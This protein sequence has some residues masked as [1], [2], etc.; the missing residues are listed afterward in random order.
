M[1]FGSCQTF[2]AV[3]VFNSV[4]PKWLW[5]LLSLVFTEYQDGFGINAARFLLSIR[6]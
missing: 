2:W 6:L 3:S 5:N 1:G 4:H